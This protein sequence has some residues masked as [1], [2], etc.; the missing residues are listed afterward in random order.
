MCFD[1]WILFFMASAI[2]IVFCIK[3]DTWLVGWCFWWATVGTFNMRLIV[4]LN[5]LICKTSGIWYS[6]FPMSSFFFLSFW[7]IPCFLL[8]PVESNLFFFFWVLTCLQFVMVIF[9]RYIWIIDISWLD[10]GLCCFWRRNPK[11]CINGFWKG[12]EFVL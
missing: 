5:L 12:K 9:F 10:A 6:T 7:Q 2:W 1:T 4:E 3:R 8:Y 11:P